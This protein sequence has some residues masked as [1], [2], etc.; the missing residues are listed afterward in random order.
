MSEPK[1]TW[2]DARPS[3]RQLLETIAKVE[4]QLKGEEAKGETKN[5]FEEMF[6]GFKRN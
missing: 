5:T 6:K 2:A 3:V 4:A 1:T